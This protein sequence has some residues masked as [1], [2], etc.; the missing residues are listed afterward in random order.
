MCTQMLVT[1]YMNES[2]LFSLRLVLILMLFACLLVIMIR[3]RTIICL[4]KEVRDKKS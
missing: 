4:L 3:M 2:L 1:T